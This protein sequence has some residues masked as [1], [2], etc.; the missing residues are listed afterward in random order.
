VPRAEDCST[1]ED[2][3]CDGASNEVETPCPCEPGDLAACYS[4]PTATLGVGLCE[5]GQ[6]SCLASG[7]G[8]GPCAGRDAADHG[9]LRDARRRRLRRDRERGC[10][11]LRVHARRAVGL[12]LGTALH[13]GHRHLQAGAADLRR[14]RT[15]GALRGRGGADPRGLQHALRR[16]LRRRGQRAL[17]RVLLLLRGAPVAAERRLR[18]QLRRVRVEKAHRAVPPQDGRRRGGKRLSALAARALGRRVRAGPRGLHAGGARRS[19]PPERRPVVGQGAHRL[20]G[21]AHRGRELPVP[22]GRGADRLRRVHSAGLT[23]RRERLRRLRR[24]DVDRAD[25]PRLVLHRPLGL[26]VL[27]NRRPPLWQ[28]AEHRVPCHRGDR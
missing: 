21:P 28:R 4:G 15:L 16:E 2:D 3:D 19:L 24:V 23:R 18:R 17:R 22:N 25:L 14:A 10:R 20:A 7:D 12:L 8:F 11:R 5:G 9:E 6:Q 26:P 13:R 1:P 27:R